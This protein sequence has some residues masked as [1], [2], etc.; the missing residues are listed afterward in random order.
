[1]LTKSQKEEIIARLKD[2]M[3]RNK[4]LV[5]ADYR[6]LTVQDMRYLKK[7]VREAGGQMQVAKKTLLNI[8]LQDAGVD[9][10][11]R[12][13]TGP[14]VFVFGP[15]ETAIPKKIW[16]YSKKNDNLK[17]EGAVLESKVLSAEE[18]VALA[19]LPSKEELLAK[20]VGAIQG[21]VSGL[22]NVMA[23]PMRSFVQALK[24]I[25]DNKAPGTRFK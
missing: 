11:T 13:F 22:V 1:M 10:D 20:L 14:L 6:G 9:F 18:T 3:S 23:G 15:E 7:E 19:K 16:N 2:A 5:M 12:S 8:V 24:A 4:V 17:I 21:P 25:S